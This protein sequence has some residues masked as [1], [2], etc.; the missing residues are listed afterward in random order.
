MTGPQRHHG[1]DLVTEPFVRLAVAQIAGVQPA[2]VQYLGGGLGTAEIALHHVVPAD[3]DLADVVAAAGSGRPKA[4]AT[5]IR[6][7]HSG[8]PIGSTFR[9]PVG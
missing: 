5:R 3:Q 6:A 2:A 1:H 4:S 8:L 9:S 7:P